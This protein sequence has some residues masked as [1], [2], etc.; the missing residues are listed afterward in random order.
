VTNEWLEIL[1]Q[2]FPFSFGEYTCQTCSRTYDHW[3]ATQYVQVLRKE[4]TWEIYRAIQAA[5]GTAESK[6]AIMAGA[7]LV[8]DMKEGDELW[9]WDAGDGETGLAIIRGG[10]VVASQIAPIF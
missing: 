6:K 4:T 10:N 2:Q 7:M 3:L 5:K 1:P 8:L 9:E